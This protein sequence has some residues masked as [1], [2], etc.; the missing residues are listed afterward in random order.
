MMAAESLSYDL[1]DNGVNL[2]RL[3]TGTPARVHK[4]SVDF[5]KM[6]IQPG[7]EK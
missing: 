4:R 6:I 3:K 7:D 1:M 5:S 2:M